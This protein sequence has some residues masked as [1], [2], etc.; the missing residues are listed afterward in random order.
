MSPN[1]YRLEN[2]T[3]K[4]FNAVL[5]SVH[6]MY[7][8]QEHIKE[9]AEDRMQRCLKKK[10][11][12]IKVY[13]TLDSNMN[14]VD[15]YAFNRC[16]YCGCSAPGLFYATYKTCKDPDGS[17]NWTDMMSKEDWEIEKTKRLNTENNAEYNISS[18]HTDSEPEPT[19]SIPEVE[20]YRDNGHGVREDTENSL[21]SDT[22]LS[23]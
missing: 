11:G 21:L 16:D 15:N 13:Q 22:D 12:C 8:E 1:P 2:F 14:L 17:I 6:N 9:Q 7:S 5:S 19:D 10:K 3:L 18:G 20:E 4:N 23:S